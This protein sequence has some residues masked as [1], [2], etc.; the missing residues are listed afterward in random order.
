MDE[1]FKIYVD[2][3]R[4]G[5][6]EQSINERLPSDFLEI[7]EPDLSFEKEVVLEGTAYIAEKE[8]IFNFSATAE[9]LISCAICNA[10]VPVEIRVV[11]FYH[12]EPL[13][14]VKAGVYNFKELLRETILLE[15]P[16][17]AECNKGNCPKRK[18]I[19]KYLKDDPTSDADKEDGYHPFADLDMGK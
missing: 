11:R 18:E 10:K 19:A 5:Q 9:A 8:L 4:R 16:V 17:I 1:R 7:D 2:R 3:L 12:A 15:V 6:D 13:E 14:N